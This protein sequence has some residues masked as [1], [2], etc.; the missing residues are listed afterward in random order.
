M[1]DGEKLGVGLGCAIKDL[2][3]TQ[4][5]ANVEFN[6]DA[7]FTVHANAPEIGG[8]AKTVLAQTAAEVLNV[9]MERITIAPYD[10]SK[11]PGA[12]IQR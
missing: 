4:Y 11:T 10:T 2:S 6:R 7:T 1:R 5:R 9:P 12:S 8:G 3:T